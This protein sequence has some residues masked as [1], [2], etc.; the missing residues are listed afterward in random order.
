MK[1]IVF[2]TGNK[3]KVEAAKNI[4]SNFDVD[5][6]SCDLSIEEPK[7]NDI[8]YISKFKVM[9]AYELLHKPCIALDAGFYIANYPN[10]PNFPGAFPKR[11]LMDKIG[12]DG[13]IEKMK[14]VEDRSCYFKECLSYYDGKEIKQFFGYCYGQISN[15]VLGIDTDKK[16]SDLWYIFIPKNCTK[17]LAQMADYERENRDD[18]HTT[19]MQEFANWFVK[20][21]FKS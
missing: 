16:W 12:I 7:I 2:V 8:E 5:F 15:D 19:A 3:G 1:K 4:F 9:K 20:Q 13:L 17:T 10:N 11:E 21:K 18:G 14:N 6:I